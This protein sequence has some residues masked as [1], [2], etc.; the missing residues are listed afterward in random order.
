MKGRRIFRISEISNAVNAGPTV[1]DPLSV[2]EYSWNQS[3]NA[4]DFTEKNVLS[5]PLGMSSENMDRP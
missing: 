1:L 5:L 3:S 2:M 4:E